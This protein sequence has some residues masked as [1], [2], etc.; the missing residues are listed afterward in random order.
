MEEDEDRSHHRYLLARHAE[1]AR[2]HGGGVPDPP[3]PRLRPADGGVQREQEE[4]TR[5]EFVA[6]GHVVE[7]RGVQRVHEPE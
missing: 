7:R 1:Q 6:V 3:A 5:Q 4:E 2:E